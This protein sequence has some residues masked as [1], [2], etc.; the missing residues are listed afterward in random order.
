VVER[1]AEVNVLRV[2]VASV[3]SLAA[4]LG[5]LTWAMWEDLQ[6]DTWETIKLLGIVLG[7]VLL[8]AAALNGIFLLWV[9]AV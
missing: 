3:V 1:G 2:V 9:W 6:A 4:F 8:I 7:V 5:L